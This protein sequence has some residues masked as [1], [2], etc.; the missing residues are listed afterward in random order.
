MEE[1]DLWTNK[2]YKKAI[3]DKLIKPIMFHNNNNGKLLIVARDKGFKTKKMNDLM[4]ILN[5]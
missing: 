4:K 3:M 1:I 2:D 5:I